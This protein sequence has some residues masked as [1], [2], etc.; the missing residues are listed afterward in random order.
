[1]STERL[2]TPPC[3]EMPELAVNELVWIWEVAELY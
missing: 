1:M 2:E 3:L